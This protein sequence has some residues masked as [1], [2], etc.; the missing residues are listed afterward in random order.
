VVAQSKYQ[1][2]FDGHFPFLTIIQYFSLVVVVAAAV[3]VGAALSIG[4]VL[5][6]Y[7]AMCPTVWHL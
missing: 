4:G 1:L 3:S 2:S 5:G 6:Q 7:S